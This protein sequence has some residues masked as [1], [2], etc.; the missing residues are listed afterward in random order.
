M[1]S[2]LIYTIFEPYDRVAIF[3]ELQ[4]NM[5]FCCKINIEP[6][7]QDWNTRPKPIIAWLIRKA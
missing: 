6:D 7:R 1:V 2:N 5:V 4:L 3:E